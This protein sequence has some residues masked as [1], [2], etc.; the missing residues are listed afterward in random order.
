MASFLQAQRKTYK[1][2]GRPVAGLGSLSLSL[3]A[4]EPG[5]Q[6]FQEARP[7]SL[8]PLCT[9]GLGRG[10]PPPGPET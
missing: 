4:W 6:A 3:R 8:W 2:A 9:P 7:P 1:E 5:V 10:H